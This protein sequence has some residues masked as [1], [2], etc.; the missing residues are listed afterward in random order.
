M[1]PS[2]PNISVFKLG[3]TNV[4][5]LELDSSLYKRV[6]LDC[7]ISKRKFKAIPWSKSRK[8]PL[9]NW[10]QKNT[11]ITNKLGNQRSKI[12]KKK[13][14]TLNINISWVHPSGPVFVNGLI[15]PNLAPFVFS[16]SLIWEG[17]MCA[18]WKESGK[19][20]GDRERQR[21]CER[22]FPLYWEEC[23]SD[24]RVIL[25]GVISRYS[26]IPPPHGNRHVVWPNHVSFR[27]C[28]FLFVLVWVLCLWLV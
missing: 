10:T 16:C 1:L 26:E 25:T 24:C 4:W 22:C 27:C 12:W 21:E 11:H 5:E 15:R 8:S 2:G 7:S 17:C 14:I 20:A 9:T 23:V 13:K 18:K 3:S 19:R 28:S 6:E